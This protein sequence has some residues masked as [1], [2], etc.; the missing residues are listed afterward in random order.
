MITAIAP[1]KILLPLVIRFS[2]AMGIFADIRVKPLHWVNRY[3][4]SN[5]RVNELAI[6]PLCLNSA[7]IPEDLGLMM[8]N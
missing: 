8:C 7:G 1:H 3:L 4:Q 5:S 6:S 2:S